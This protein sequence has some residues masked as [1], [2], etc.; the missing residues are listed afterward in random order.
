[1]VSKRGRGQDPPAGA[2][3]Q[4]RHRTPAAESE[5]DTARRD[6]PAVR[7]RLTQPAL[8]GSTRQGRRHGV[9][10]TGRPPRSLPVVMLVLLVPLD[11]LPAFARAALRA[12]LGEAGS[13]V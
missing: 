8:S 4:T 1:A 7:P 9:C 13:A 10:E 2:V 12:R 11:L 3:P 6:G 5:A